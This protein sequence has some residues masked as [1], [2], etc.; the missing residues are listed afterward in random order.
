M[1]DGKPIRKTI[2][3][4]MQRYKILNRIIQ[5]KNLFKTHKARKL[6]CQLL[7]QHQMSFA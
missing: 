3:F 5:K 4:S 1:R 6:E 2:V 7:G